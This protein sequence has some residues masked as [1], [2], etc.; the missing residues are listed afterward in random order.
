[1]KPIP[2]TQG[3]YAMVDDCDFERISAVRWSAMKG[4]TTFYAG[5][6]DMASRTTILMHR[7][8]LGLSPSG[9]KLGA[10]WVDHR[11]GNGLNNCRRNL[12][13]ATQAQNRQ[14]SRPRKDGRLGL[15]GVSQEG[16]SFRARI[17][18]DG[19]TYELGKFST[20]AGAASAYNTAARKL[21]G[22]YARLNKVG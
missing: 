20:A 9:R 1:M 22:E 3:L 4:T 6:E 21:F 17:Y 13:L 11:D 8:V 5:R 2:L 15:K 12:R 7:V 16:N 19:I 18:R 10:I 14:N